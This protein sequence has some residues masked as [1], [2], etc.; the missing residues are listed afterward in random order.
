MSFS[1][2]FHADEKEAQKSAQIAGCQFTIDAGRKTACHL[3]YSQSA[4]ARFLLRRA[5]LCDCIC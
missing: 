1:K 5:H 3:F 2:Q 4:D